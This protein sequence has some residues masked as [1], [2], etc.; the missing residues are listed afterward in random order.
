VEEQADT[1]LIVMRQ[2]KGAQV[3][4]KFV[5]ATRRAV[6]PLDGGAGGRS[7]QLSSVQ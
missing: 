3:E 1:L 4:V 6:D 2:H 7:A 5:E